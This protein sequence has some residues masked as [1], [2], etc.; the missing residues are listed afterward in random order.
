MNGLEFQEIYDV[1]RAHLLKQNKKSI[2]SRHGA[3]LYRADDGC[4]CAIGILIKDEFYSSTLEYSSATS[5]MV[6]Q[7]LKLSGISQS[8]INI[9]S[10]LNGLQS[11]HDRYEVDDWKRQLDLFANHWDLKIN[12]N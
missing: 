5:N 6:I 9:P 11:I 7:I 3:C 10:F 1:V 2:S 4:K 12:G 8:I